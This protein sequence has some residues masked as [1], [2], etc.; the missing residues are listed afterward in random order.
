MAAGRGYGRRG[1]CDF[2]LGAINGG[3]QE[4]AGCLE[5]VIWDTKVPFLLLRSAS[6]AT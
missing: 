4:M 1:L 5:L 3:E 2:V 6:G